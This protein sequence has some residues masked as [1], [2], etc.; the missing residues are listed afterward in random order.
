ML[1]Y[2]MLFQLQNR[3][4]RSFLKTV[5]QEGKKQCPY[6]DPLFFIKLK[7]NTTTKLC[8]GHK[9]EKNIMRGGRDG[10]HLRV[11]LYSLQQEQLLPRV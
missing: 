7:K 4:S 10:N 1:Q 3:T 8:A 6:A 11:N 2:A 5:I 9:I